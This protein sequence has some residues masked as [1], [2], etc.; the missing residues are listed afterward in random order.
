MKHLLA[1]LKGSQNG[2]LI[3]V[4]LLAVVHG[5]RYYRTILYLEFELSEFLNRV[6]IDVNCLI[7]LIVLIDTFTTV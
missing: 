3:L 4:A 6:M 1:V 7:I 5:I 2:C